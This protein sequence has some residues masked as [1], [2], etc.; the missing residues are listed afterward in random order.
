MLVRIIK[1]IE[2]FI[3]SRKAYRFQMREWTRLN[4][5][6]GAAEIDRVPIVFTADGC[7]FG[8]A[9]IGFGC[10]AAGHENHVD[11]A[12]AFTCQQQ[13]AAGAN[14]LVVGMRRNHRDPLF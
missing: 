9:R 4:D 6:D 8:I 12:A 7:T 3:W 1:R 2:G 11:R 14:H 5:L 10:G 13:G